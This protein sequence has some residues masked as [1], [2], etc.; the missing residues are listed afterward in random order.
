MITGF[1]VEISKGK[2]AF[3]GI[4]R[5][6]TCIILQLTTTTQPHLFYTR[7]ATANATSI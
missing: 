2:F 6:N 5:I 3:P 7:V 4:G 1:Q